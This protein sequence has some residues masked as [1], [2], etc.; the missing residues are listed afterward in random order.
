MSKSHPKQL[1]WLGDSLEV[2][3]AFPEQA[4][5][6]AGHQLGMV[7]A[8]L[9]PVDWKPMETVGAGVKE[10]RIRVEQAYRVFYVAKFGEA[11]YVLHAFVKKTQ[12]ASKA[13]LDL[14]AN[15]YRALLKAR[16]SK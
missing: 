6:S 14:A 10:I 11:V 7:Q 13:D 16:T 2:V 8:G 3:K 15:R 12:K 4:R 1:R 9:D 5:R